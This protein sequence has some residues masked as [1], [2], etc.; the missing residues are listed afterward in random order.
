M[1]IAFILFDHMTALDLV[2]VYDPVTRLRSMNILPDLC[3]Q[4]CAVREQVQDDRGL[5]FIPT[6]GAQALDDYDALIVPGGFGTRALMHDEAFVKW[7]QTAAGCPVKASVCTGALLLGA[8]GFLK[9]KRA[10]THPTAFE[11]LRPFCASVVVDQRVVDEG[12]VITSRGVTAGI[13]LGLYLVEKIAGQAARERIARQMD[14]H[15]PRF[16]VPAA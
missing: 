9:G 1:N 7:L 13:D 10:T 15:A 4:V 12:D 2:G 16:S 6:R 3:W 14:Y 8:A 11:E 5:H